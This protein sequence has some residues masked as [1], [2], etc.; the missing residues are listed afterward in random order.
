MKQGLKYIGVLVVVVAVGVLFYNWVYLP[1]S[2][3][4]TLNVSRGNITVE[5]QGIG[6]V[7]AKNIYAVSAQV[8]GAIVSIETD[9]GEWVQKGD[10]IA[11]IDPLELPLQLQETQLAVSKAKFE[12]KAVAHEIEA[13]QAQKQLADVTLMRY[14]KLFKQGYVAQQEYDK[15]LS[16]FESITAQL[17][18]TEAHSESAKKEVARM[19]KNVASLQLRLSRFHVYAPIDGY[20]VSK[21][22]ETAQN[23]TPAQPIVTVI[24]P[25]DVWIQAHIDERISGAIERGQQAL[26][27]LRSRSQTPL[28]GYVARISAMSDAVTQEREVNI[29]FDTTPIPFYIN[30]QAEVAI[31]TQSIRSVLR[32]PLSVLRRHQGD[33]GVWTVHENKAHFVALEI[34]A[35]GKKYGAFSRG[36]QEGDRIIV[37]DPNKKPL[38]EGMRVY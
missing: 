35:R 8:S 22:A 16:D 4:Q 6:T 34:T 9:E 19:Q 31:V 20:V 5:A 15:A 14:K 24:N 2:T 25:K 33:E 12:Q 38:R 11:V 21:D 7:S 30:E 23:V 26:I 27:T 28:H 1:K 18:A 10:L 13:L 3:F 17:A 32:V 36:L 37:P 29:A